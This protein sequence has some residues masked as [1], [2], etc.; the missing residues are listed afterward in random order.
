MGSKHQ[1]AEEIEESAYL[2]SAFEVSNQ[3]KKAGMLQIVS[4]Q[5]LIGT[6]SQAQSCYNAAFFQCQL[7]NQQ[8]GHG[9]FKKTFDH[10]AAQN[11]SDVS[12]QVQLAEKPTQLTS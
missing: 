9:F 8:Q 10:L 4:F 3:K 5:F 1:S 7:V 12:I 11:M 2:Y 6:S